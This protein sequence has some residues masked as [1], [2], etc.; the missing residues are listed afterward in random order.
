MSYGK[1]RQGPKL[2]YYGHTIQLQWAM[3]E[4]VFGVNAALGA[5]KGIA[6]KAITTSV[7]PAART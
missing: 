2:G 5:E 4:V 3:C 6:A 1:R 7:A